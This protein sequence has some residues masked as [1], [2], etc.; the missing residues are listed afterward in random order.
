MKWYFNK[1]KMKK[2]E[3]KICKLFQNFY[4]LKKSNLNDINHNLYSLKQKS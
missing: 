2:K 1:K 3:V 4:N